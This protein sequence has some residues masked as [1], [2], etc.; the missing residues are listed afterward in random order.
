[1][2]KVSALVPVP[3]RYDYRADWRSCGVEWRGAKREG[4]GHEVAWQEDAMSYGAAWLGLVVMLP[5]LVTVLSYCLILKVG[6][7]SKKSSFRY[8]TRNLDERR[9]YRLCIWVA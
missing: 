5:L 7:C 1:M 6:C 4:A 9:M 3:R 8:G 2:N